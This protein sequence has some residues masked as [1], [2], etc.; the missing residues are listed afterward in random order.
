MSDMSSLVQD[1]TSIAEEAR[2]IR[3]FSVPKHEEDPSVQALDL[4]LGK[5]NTDYGRPFSFSDAPLEVDA[6]SFLAPY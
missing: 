5:F 3:Y 4:R 2:R 1:W 6:N